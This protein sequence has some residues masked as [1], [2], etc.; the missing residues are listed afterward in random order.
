MDS[1]NHKQ[2]W[3]FSN[4]QGTPNHPKLDHFS[5]ET[6]GFGD[7]HLR[8][9]PYIPMA[10]LFACT[11]VRQQP[12]RGPPWPRATEHQLG[13]FPVHGTRVQIHT[14]LRTD[15]FHDGFLMD[16][17]VVLHIFPAIFWG[18]WCIFRECVSKLALHGRPNTAL[19]APW[20][21]G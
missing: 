14:S 5:I 1:G 13:R 3:I 8:K 7:P 16:L 15:H 2:L 21:F 20:C 12:K 18:I 6:Y 17:G 4:L 10:F 19:L 9:Q 11:L